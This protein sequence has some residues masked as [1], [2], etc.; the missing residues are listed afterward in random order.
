[1]KAEGEGGREEG[2]S[3]ASVGKELEKPKSAAE[4]QRKQ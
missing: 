4:E 3:L 2:K 1:M